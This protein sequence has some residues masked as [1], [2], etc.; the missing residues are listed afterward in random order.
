MLDFLKRCARSL[1]TRLALILI[2]AAVALHIVTGELFFRFQHDRDTALRR[3]LVQ[4]AHF[5]AQEL[6]DPPDRQRAHE[7]GEQLMMRIS[8]DGPEQWTAGLEPSRFPAERLRQMLTSGN[9]EVA[10]VHGYSRIRVRTGPESSL[11]FD[12]FPSPAERQDRYSFRLIF[13][14]V[15]CFILLTAYILMRYLLRPVRW[16]TEGAASVRDGCL[17]CRV[18][19]KSSGELH[20]LTH[21][22]NQM[23]ARLER[24][25]QSQKGLLLAVSHELRT[26]LTRLKLQLEM[27]GDKSAAQA[28]QEDVHEMELLINSI[29]E[30]ARMQHDVSALKREKTDMVALLAD[31]VRR[32]AGQPP[33]V[34][35]DLPAGQLWAEVD[36]DRVAIL[37]SNL[38]DNAL[39]YSGQDAEPVE[40]HCASENGDIVITV[41]D[42][43][44]GIPEEAVDR[45]FEPFFRVD[46]SR[47]RESGGY[48]L[49]LSLCQ[50]I[51]RAHG[52][53]IA[54][55]S[56]PGA[57]TTI[58]VTLPAAG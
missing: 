14:G 42:H 55:E 34:V 25:M 10:G 5:L 39:K 22:F 9:V 7:L 11:T 43:G 36:Q 19:E 13:L 38:L 54:I 23:V 47:T 33:G 58:T 16:L 15:M 37:V 6:G 40:L 12:I 26:P 2:L 28:M 52:G 49:G 20:D 46:E 32:F 1:F 56:R 44:I 45:L 3:N 31:T 27:M 8:A 35:V 51:V 24:V 18:S 30:A 29:L 48:G 53:D 57:G 21:T 17:S 50:A 41:R 4:Y